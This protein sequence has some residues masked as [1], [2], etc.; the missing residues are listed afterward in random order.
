VNDPPH[1]GGFGLGLKVGVAEVRSEGMLLAV[2]AIP[3][4]MLATSGKPAG[5]LAGWTA[6]Y[7][8]DGFRCQ[9]A[10]G[11]VGPAGLYTSPD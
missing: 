1:L 8:A 9:I 10:A 11:R 6:E 3:G 7:K 4:P 2:L 5:S